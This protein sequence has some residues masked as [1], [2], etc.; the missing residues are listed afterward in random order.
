VFDDLEK[1]EEEIDVSYFKATLQKITESNNIS[2]FR[3]HPG[4]LTG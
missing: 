4:V 1:V 3:V 2:I